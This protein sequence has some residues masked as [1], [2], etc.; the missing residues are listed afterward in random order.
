MILTALIHSYFAVTYLL[1]YDA[2]STYTRVRSMR[3]I[4]DIRYFFIT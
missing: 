1:M 4:M 3:N 2:Y